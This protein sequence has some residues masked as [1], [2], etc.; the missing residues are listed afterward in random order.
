MS[1]SA[2]LPGAATFTASFTALN[3]GAQSR[4]LLLT[5]DRN[6]DFTIGKI[7]QTAHIL[8]GRQK[9]VEPGIFRRRQQIGIRSRS[10]CCADWVPFETHAPLALPGMISTT[11]HCDESR[12]TTAINH[13]VPERS[14]K[15]PRYQ[16]LH[17]GA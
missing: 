7:L 14:G 13:Q 12:L 11:R 5:K 8:V 1:N 2:T 17:L 16:A 10:C 15:Y 6:G 4:P 3:E 9:W